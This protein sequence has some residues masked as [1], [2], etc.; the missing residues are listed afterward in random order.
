[1]E[2]QRKSTE[3]GKKEMIDLNELDNLLPD[4]LNTVLK[5]IREIQSKKREIVLDFLENNQK[6]KTCTL[7]ELYIDYLT[8]CKNKTRVPISE[9]SFNIAVVRLHDTKI[10]TLKHLKLKAEP[11]I[12]TPEKRQEAI[13]TK[14]SK[15]ET[16]VIESGNENEKLTI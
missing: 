8:Y 9:S 16:P 10:V 1:M 3:G 5:K 7:K 2:G 11:K 4:E 13:G 6:E 14:V 12:I 15:I